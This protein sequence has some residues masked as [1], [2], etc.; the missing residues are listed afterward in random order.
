VAHL[1]VVATLPSF[2]ERRN[3]IADRISERRKWA[4][5]ESSPAGTDPVALMKFRFELAHGAMVRRY[6]PGR[7]SGRV[8]HFVPNRK[9]VSSDYAP[10]RW[11]RV[12]PHLE[13][14]YG[15]E[16]VDP[17]RMLIEPHVHAF[18][19]LF[20]RCRQGNAVTAAS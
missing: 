12:A 7:F 3:Y 4:R 11:R 1:K 8:C 13:Q 14:Y 6:T 9:W 2:E 19:E 18:A 5:I 15:P 20:R 10:E 16:S 17:D